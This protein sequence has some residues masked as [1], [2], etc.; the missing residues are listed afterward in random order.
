M[1]NKKITKEFKTQKE[2]QDHLLKLPI[3]LDFFCPLIQKRCNPD[4]ICFVYKGVKINEYKAFDNE[5]IAHSC[6]CDHR[7]MHG[8]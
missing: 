6:Y 4:C 5:Y 1:P 7:G 8:G 3:A 2:A